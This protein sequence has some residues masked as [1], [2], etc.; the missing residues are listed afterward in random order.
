MIEC[1]KIVSKIGRICKL[2]GYSIIVSHL[3]LHVQ[4]DIECLNHV[5]I[6][7]LRLLGGGSDGTRTATKNKVEIH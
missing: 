7:G 2:D 6:V 1:I 3:N 4:E 5:V